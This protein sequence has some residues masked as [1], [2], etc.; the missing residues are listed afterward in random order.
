MPYCSVYENPLFAGENVRKFG[1]KGWRAGGFDE[2]E[3]DLRFTE[4]DEKLFE[5]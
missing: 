5:M 4:D 2:E 3:D 1:S